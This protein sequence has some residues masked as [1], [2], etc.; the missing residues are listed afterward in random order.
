MGKKSCQQPD[1]RLDSPD[2]E[3]NG[4]HK[5]S[6]NL[7]QLTLQA[8]TVLFQATVGVSWRMEKSRRRHLQVSDTVGLFHNRNHG[9][10][11]RALARHPAK[12]QRSW[13][14][15]AVRLAERQLNC[16]YSIAQAFEQCKEKFTYSSTTTHFSGWQ[17][18]PQK[19]QNR[20]QPILSKKTAALAYSVK[21]TANW[22]FFL[23]LLYDVSCLQDRDYRG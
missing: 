18:I 14:E 9:S 17:L 15:L 13:Q 3:S 12:R 2:L 20:C 1:E 8:P 19:K 16:S 22:L 10:R 23:S 4:D 11:G 5:Q 6:T 21:K 7:Q